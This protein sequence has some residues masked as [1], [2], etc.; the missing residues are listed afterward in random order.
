MAYLQVRRGGTTQ[1]WAK[2][3][4]SPKGLGLFCPVPALL[5]ASG[6]V[7]YAALLAP[8]YEPK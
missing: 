2:D 1:N 7:G 5:V 8:W 6:P 3:G 4:P